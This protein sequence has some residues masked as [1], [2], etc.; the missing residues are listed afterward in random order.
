MNY[1]EEALNQM[2]SEAINRPEN[3]VMKGI[4]FTN[5]GAEL[6]EITPQ[7]IIIAEK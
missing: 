7:Q 5:D 3:K 1:L 6:I 2:L 4:L